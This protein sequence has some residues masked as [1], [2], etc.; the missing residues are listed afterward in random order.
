MIN[1]PT[2]KLTTRELE[3]L[4]RVAQGFSDVEISKQLG[5]KAGT[6][7]NTLG[8]IRLK[9]SAYTNKPLNKRVN[10]TTF[11]LENLAIRNQD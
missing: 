2:V 7:R 8:T 4:H 6:V 10:L 9:L 3:T 1:T 5:N 11:Y